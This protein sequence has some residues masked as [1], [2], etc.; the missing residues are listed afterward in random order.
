MNAAQKAV[1][2]AAQAKGLSPMEQSSEFMLHDLVQACLDALRQQTKPFNDLGEQQQDA[3]ISTLQST[4]KKTV[5][6]A[7][8]ILLGAEVIQVP[9]ILTGFTAKKEIQI[10]GV[11]ESDHPGRLQLMDK[12]HL[13]AKVV[14]LLQDMDYFGGL[15]NITSDK[16]QRPLDWE[17]DGKAAKKSGSGKA[18]EKSA[19]PKPIT[20]PAKMLTDARDFVIIQQNTT[21]PGL[22]NLL[23]IDITKAERIHQL[24]EEEGVLTAK[25]AAGA[26]QLK[27][28]GSGNDLDDAGASGGGDLTGEDTPVDL[29]D[30][31]YFAIRDT[32]VKRQSVSVGVLMVDHALPEET[33]L[34]AIERL[35]LDGVVSPEDDMGGRHVLVA[36]S[37]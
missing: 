19:E 21:I 2:E 27:R 9:M 1:L 36:A 5:F 26:R 22:Q 34:D 24:L 6:T 33:V 3:V 35:E 4:L 12:A 15:D 31:I 28:E 11:I 30:E 8:Q 7:A 29:T 20:I 32:V 16:D 14:V 17:G 25:D 23:K 37:E 18:K 13:K 10:T